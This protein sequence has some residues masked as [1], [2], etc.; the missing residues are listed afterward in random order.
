MKKN[1][2]LTIL[3][4][5]LLVSC[6]PT[7]PQVSPPVEQVTTTESA[8]EAAPVSVAT[9]KTETEQP[10]SEK[11]TEVNTEAQ[12]QPAEFVI[13]EGR[14]LII[15]TPGDPPGLD[16]QST[17]GVGVDVVFDMYNTLIAYNIDY[18]NETYI[19]GEF[20]PEIAES[21]EVADDKK[22]IT[23]HINP[24]AK[25]WDGNSITA[26][27]VRFS[28]ERSIDGAVGWGKTQLNTGGITSSDQAEVIDDL[29]VRIN[30]PDGL[31][32][33][34]IRNFAGISLTIVSKDYILANATSDDP[35]A[36]NHL[37]QNPM[38]S[39]PYKFESWTSGESIIL[40]AWEDYWGDIKPYYSGLNWR[41]VPDSQTRMLLMKS[42][43][44][45]IGDV[46]PQ[47]LVQ[48]EG[49]PNIRIISVPRNQ[50]IL[51][52]RWNPTQPPFDDPNIRKAI[53][54]AIPYDTIIND[55]LF[56]YG[57]RVKNLIGVSSYGYKELP[58]YETNLEEAKQ[59]VQDSKYPTGAKF[60]L[61]VST[62][63]PERIAAAVHI[64]SALREIGIEMEIEQV[65]YAAYFDRAS[66]KEYSVNL[67]AMGP[68]WSDSL[69]Y[70]Y[71]MF[72]T[73][74]ATN[75]IS[76]SDPEL[77]EAAKS[78]LMVPYDDLA[79]YDELARIVYDDTLIAEYIAA[80]L[81]QTNWTM[82]V[83]SDIKDIIYYGWAR[84]E[85]VHLRPVE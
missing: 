38:G 43:E 10:I 80:P 66:K 56:G 33:Y 39:G 31:N 29:T 20:I 19:E 60:T 79:T 46:A 50:D 73:D 21:W 5:F 47:D 49:D 45:D 62:S 42:G 59:L 1:L 64:Q 54:K 75:Y 70:A 68:W 57:T 61:V 76:F 52:F 12:E 58:L 17:S 3:I 30:F 18:E 27:D 67:H 65:P 14:Q 8:P 74:S 41:I 53:I 25:F 55:V 71:W 40:S 16:P 34:S 51:T 63:F 85:H 28:I 83:K 48:L 36:A 6:S 13:G 22:S 37:K 24:N 72:H 9:E 2:A 11:P 44:A 7:S 84:I 82:A 77:D 4:V 35:Y 15:L 81:Y 78:A 23:F 26:E 32:R 69:Y